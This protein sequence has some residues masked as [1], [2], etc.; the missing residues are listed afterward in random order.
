MICAELARY[1]VFIVIDEILDY[2]TT[3]IAQKE[4]EAALW[5]FLQTLQASP[6]LT[7]VAH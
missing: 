4:I 7:K 1:R 5:Q 2:H 3:D 6:V